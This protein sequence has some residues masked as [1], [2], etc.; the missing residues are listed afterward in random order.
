MTLAELRTALRARLD[1]DAGK[2]LWS[3]PELDSY[4]NRALD[5]ACL[6]GRMLVDDSTP[7]ICRIVTVQDQARYALDDRVIEV[8]RVQ[9]EGAPKPMQ[10]TTM[11][12]LDDRTSGDWES[13]TGKP[14]TWFTDPTTS[15]NLEKKI[16]LYRTPNT[17]YA[18]LTVRLMV[19][20]LHIDPLEGDD[21]E[22]YELHQSMHRDLLDWGERE[23]FLKHD[24]ETYSK[25]KSESA[26][27]RFERRFGPRPT[28]N[29]L[30][31]RAR[32]ITGRVRGSFF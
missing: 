30:A 24:S 21:D 31:Q 18:G 27:M 19:V 20:R 26:E 11:A 12:Q 3:D 2:Q 28:L 29:V 5:E 23:A 32:G 7:E 17:D 22:P 4:L 25:D 9:L 14:T 1:D 16:G 15:V 13:H 6:R 8:V 10:K